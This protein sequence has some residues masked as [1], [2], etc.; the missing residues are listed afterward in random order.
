[1]PPESVEPK[2]LGWDAINAV[3][4][5][6]FG[7]QEPRNW[8]PILPSM[9]GGSDPLEGV[10]AYACDEPRHW[11]FVT[12]GFS[13]LYEKEWEDPELSGFGF[14]L[15]FRLARG[16]EAEPPIWCVNFLQNLARYV[17]QSGNTFEDGHHLDL[18]SPIALDL[19]TKIRAIMFMDDPQMGTIQT[20]NGRVQ[21]LQIMG[22]SLDELRVLK[23][24]RSEK[25]LE[26]LTSEIPLGLTDLSRDTLLSRPDV[27][28]KVE[29]GCLQ[30]GSSTGMLYVSRLAWERPD[31]QGSPGAA[32]TVIIGAN[33]VRDLGPVLK[34]R[35]P[36]G[37]NLMIC[38][39][40]AVVGFEP[41]ERCGVEAREKDGFTSL[42]IL[43]TAQ[44]ARELAELVQPK[45]GTYVLVEWPE[46][47][48]VVERSEIKDRE[49]KVVEVIG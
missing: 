1:M 36:H 41:G 24:W 5:R 19:P 15:T 28:Q 27:R 23:R 43:L 44:A 21:F 48:I 11:H 6:L 12:Y 7:E 10:S 8:A 20:P 30:D 46:L 22:I 9:L 37:E 33:G 34:G 4:R 38:A 47:R 13:E 17:F 3:C 35:I 29:E 18:N 16:E 42:H 14:E 40:D 2:A 25:F 49:G 31:G 26:L 45:A 39:S 32:T